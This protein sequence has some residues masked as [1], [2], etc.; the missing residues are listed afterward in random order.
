MRR[1]PVNN[2]IFIRNSLFRGLET[3]K[4]EDNGYSST[5]SCDTDTDS[6]SGLQQSMGYWHDTLLNVLHNMS[7][8][9]DNSTNSQQILYIQNCIKEIVFLSRKIPNYTNNTY[10]EDVKLACQ[11]ISWQNMDSKTIIISYIDQEIEE[12][13]K[14]TEHHRHEVKDIF[15]H[16]NSV[17]SPDENNHSSVFQTPPKQIKSPSNQTP[18]VSAYPHPEISKKRKLSAVFPY[19]PAF[20]LADDDVVAEGKERHTATR[21]SASSSR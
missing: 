9:K 15:E 8:K 20:T 13:K 21:G 18:E 11:E 19:I 2:E 16:F 3:Y 4:N 5:N 1:L 6:E 14:T 12:L 17:K 7:Q 10:L